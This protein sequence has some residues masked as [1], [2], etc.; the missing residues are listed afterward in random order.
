MYYD[1]NLQDSEKILTDI[2]LQVLSVNTDHNL[3]IHGR[4]IRRQSLEKKY[5]SVIL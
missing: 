1:Q 3:K 4:L 2:I 5:N